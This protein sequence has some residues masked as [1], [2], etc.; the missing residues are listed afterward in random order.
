M[1]GLTFSNELISRDE[2]MHC[3]FACLLY[4]HILNKLPEEHV[5]SLIASAVKIEQEFVSQA[6][7]VELIGMNSTLMQQYIEFCADRLMVALGYNKMYNVQNPFDWMTMISLQGKTNFFEKRV[8]EYAKAG[9]GVK[10]EDQVFT[11]DAEF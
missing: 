8:G 3:D 10:Q 1:P 2:G 11:L 4:K 6:L 7:P 5:A 9:V